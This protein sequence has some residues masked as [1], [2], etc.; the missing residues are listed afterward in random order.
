MEYII[1]VKRPC[2]KYYSVFIKTR[3]EECAK[4]A[5]EAAETYGWQ[6]R[7]GMPIMTR[8]EFK[9]K[10]QQRGN[11]NAKDVEAFTKYRKE[12]TQNDFAKLSRYAEKR[13]QKEAKK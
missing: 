3:Q 4:N 5:I 7:H 2:D 1:E 6:W 13:R 12:F 9:S 8:D 11:W 10:C